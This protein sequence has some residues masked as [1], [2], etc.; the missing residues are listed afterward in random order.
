MYGIVERTVCIVVAAAWIGSTVC[1][2][3]GAQQTASRDEEVARRPRSTEEVETE[4]APA[5]PLARQAAELRERAIAMGRVRVMVQVKPEPLA[6]ERVAEAAREAGAT[7]LRPA[8]GASILLLDVDAAQLDRILETGLV[9]SL[10]ADA[11]EELHGSPQAG[12]PFGPALA[13]HVV[14]Y[15]RAG[16]DVGAQGSRFDI[17]PATGSRFRAAQ[18][19]PQM[20]AINQRLTQDGVS[21]LE[22]VFPN[23]VDDPDD[24]EDD[25]LHLAFYIGLPQSIARSNI[26]ALAAWLEQ[27]PLVDEAYVGVVGSEPRPH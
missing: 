25:Q 8:E 12:A 20:S 11:P 9:V 23:H 15:F 13:G 1:G 10:Q 7:V 27:S 14:V 22:R 4:R 19:A 16:L 24:P 6:G 18:V 17:R 2:C 5:D 21:E 26:E 3:G